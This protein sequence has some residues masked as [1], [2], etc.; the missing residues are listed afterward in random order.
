VFDKL[1][2]VI[3]LRYQVS[4]DGYHYQ[5]ALG[6]GSFYRPSAEQLWYISQ[7]D[8]RRNELLSMAYGDLYEIKKDE[9]VTTHDDNGTHIYHHLI[10]ILTPKFKPDPKAIQRVH[11]SF[12]IEK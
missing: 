1:P 3:H 8:E 5:S 9:Y 12:G 6:Y 11:E 7:E 4:D 10:A 2:K